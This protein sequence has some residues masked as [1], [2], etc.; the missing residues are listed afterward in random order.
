[1][2]ERHMVRKYTD[3]PIPEDI[4]EKLNHRVRENNE[5]YGLSI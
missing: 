1:M 5:Q 4:V 2:K 3:E